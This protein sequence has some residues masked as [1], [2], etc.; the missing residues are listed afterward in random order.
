MNGLIRDVE[1][2]MRA[3]AK[4]E[5][6]SRFGQLH[7]HDI[8]AKDRPGDVVTVADLEAEVRL[9]EGLSNLL[10]DSTQVG[11][12]ECYRDPSVLKRLK[13]SKPVWT[14][15][16]LD[17]TNNFAKGKPCFAMI[18]ALVID[19]KTEMGWILDPIADVCAT[20]QR[21]KGVRIVDRKLTMDAPKAIKDMTGS[22]GDMM[23]PKIQKRM[24]KGEPALPRHLIRHHCCG[25]EYLDLLVGK[26]HFV[27][28]GGKLMPWDHAAGVLMMEEVGA[29]ARIRK[30]KE[31][32]D[33]AV[34]G[35]GAELFIA[36]SEVAYDDLQQSLFKA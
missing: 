31:A 19:G 29:F 34:H 10:P 17:G 24:K 5:I 22:L 7:R 2:L 28:Y 1:E 23:R 32:Y 4:D 6:L 3:V 21:G 11:E 8:H 20:A 25:R 27:H 15:D 30:G 12:E 26:L 14:V 16:P 13:G 36:P 33:P 9:I 18:C 35:Q